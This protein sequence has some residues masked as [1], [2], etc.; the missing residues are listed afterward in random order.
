[1]AQAARKQPAHDEVPP[2]D[3]D[4]VERAYRLERAKR[5]A[6]MERQR[7]SRR[8]GIRFAVTMILLLAFS[9]ALVVLIWQQVQRLFGL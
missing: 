3:P 7:A 6:R 4:A 2:V 9:V 1:M 5:R 8:A